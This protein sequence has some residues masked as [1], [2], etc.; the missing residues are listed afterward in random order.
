[1]SGVF[2]YPNILRQYASTRISLLVNSFTRLTNN[3]CTNNDNRAPCHYLNLDLR[4]TSVVSLSRTSSGRSLFH[5]PEERFFQ[6][7][8]ENL[9]RK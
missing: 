4:L 2:S 7:P 8:Q 1:M 3:E 6:Q 5:R 9:P